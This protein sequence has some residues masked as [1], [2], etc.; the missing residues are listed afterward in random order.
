MMQIVQGDE[1]ILPVKIKQGT[2][3]LTPTDVSDVR[4][5]VGDTLKTYSK[6][7]LTFNTTTNEWLYQLTQE[8][9]L[10]FND[11]RVLV[12][13]GVKTTNDI[14]YSTSQAIY[15]DDNIIKKEW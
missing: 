2:S 14:V 9:T 13:V 4:I 3:T 1:Y 6:N 15:V 8:Q 12:Q 5:Q 7:E 10:A 11:A